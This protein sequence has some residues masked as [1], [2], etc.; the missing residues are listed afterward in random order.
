[1]YL[2]KCS[3]AAGKECKGEDGLNKVDCGLHEVAKQRRYFCSS[4]SC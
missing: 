2:Q 3:G 4:Q 1:M